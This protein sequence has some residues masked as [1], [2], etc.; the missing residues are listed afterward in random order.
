MRACFMDDPETRRE[1]KCCS[2]LPSKTKKPILILQEDEEKDSE[3][4]EPITKMDPV[5]T[6]PISDQ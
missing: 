3:D 5:S 2:E 6:F 1:P 4:D